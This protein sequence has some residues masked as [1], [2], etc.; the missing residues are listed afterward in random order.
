MRTTNSCMIVAF[1]IFIHANSIGQDIWPL[2]DWPVATP[3]S[4]SMNADSLQA[5]DDDITS[6]KYGNIDKMI[7][8][9]NGKLLYQKS[10]T[11]DYDKIYNDSASEKER[12]KST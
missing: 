5:F 10:Y 6:G 3:Q 12:I 1:F 8:T 9:R 11:H 7:I 2:R 4:G